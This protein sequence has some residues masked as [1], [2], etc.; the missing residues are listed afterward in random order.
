MPPKPI[1]WFGRETRPDW[2]AQQSPAVAASVRFVVV[3]P[4]VFVVVV[5][6]VLVVAVF[7]AELPVAM[8]G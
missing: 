1:L 3:V 6:F 2:V 5:V 7:V 8:L 4:V